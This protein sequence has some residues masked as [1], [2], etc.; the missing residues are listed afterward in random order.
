MI[1]GFSVDSFLSCVDIINSK[2]YDYGNDVLYRDFGFACLP[3]PGVSQIDTKLSSIIWIIGK[4]YSADPTRSAPKGTFSNKGLGSSFEY[5]A[6]E[7]HAFS[8][9]NRFYQELRSLRGKV[10]SYRYEDDQF[11]LQQTVKLVETLNEMVKSAMEKAAAKKEVPENKSDNVVSFCSKFL[12][13][14]CPD[15]FFIIDSYSFNGGI[16]LFSG[17]AN[18]ILYISE[19]DPSENLCIDKDTRGYFKKTYSHPDPEVDYSDSIK[20]YYKH[21]LR[22]YHLACFLHDNKKTCTPQIDGDPNSRYMPRLVDSI[23]MRIT[24]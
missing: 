4:T 6:K 16:A 14:M 15:L 11:I 13:F 22:A 9:Y 10:Y 12:H 17:N 19:D 8:H 23:L 7:I 18:R 3:E 20:S 21:C 5:I 24:E 2:N 1:M